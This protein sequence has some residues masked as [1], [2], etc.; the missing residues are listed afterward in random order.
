M[1]EQEHLPE[2]G[3]GPI[4]VAI[5]MILTF[6]GI[7][8][9]VFHVIHIGNAE[10]LKIPFLVLGIF[11]IKWLHNLYGDEYDAYCRH[12]NHCIPWIRK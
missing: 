10:F 4:Y 12:V 11:L 8:L 3:V 9:S 5:I 7:L 2:I 6:I 1:K